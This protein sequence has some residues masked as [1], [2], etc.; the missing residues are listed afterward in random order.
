MLVNLTARN[1]Q[2]TEALKNHIEKKVRR[3]DRYVDSDTEAQMV[4]SIEKYR[5]LVEISLISR[6]INLHSTEES[7]DMYLSIDKALDKIKRQL[8]KQRE[9]RRGLKVRQRLKGPQ[10]L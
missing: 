6:S 3:L 8:K 5:H 4:L 10:G 1:L 9:R 7:P 2:I